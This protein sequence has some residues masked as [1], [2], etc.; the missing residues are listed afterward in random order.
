MV[1]HLNIFQYDSVYNSANSAISLSKGYINANKYLHG[2]I[3]LDD[4]IGLE[5]TYTQ[6]IKSKKTY[7]FDRVKSAINKLDAATVNSIKEYLEIAPEDKFT[8][9]SDTV[10][11]LIN[12]L[13]ENNIDF[14]FTKLF[15]NRDV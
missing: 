1:V 15:E 10:R 2:N 11:G 12:I 3:K 5:D 7:V 8:N 4:N 13:I 14:D 6:N 9:L